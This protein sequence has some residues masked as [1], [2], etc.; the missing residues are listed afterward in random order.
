MIF[1]QINVLL[2]VAT[3]AIIGI[4]KLPDCRPPRWRKRTQKL[5]LAAMLLCFSASVHA[6]DAPSLFS[7]G[8]V[9]LSPFATASIVDSE[10]SY[11]GGL[12]LGYSLTEKLTVE[13]EVTS[14]GIDDSQWL[15]S[16]RDAGGN[17]KYYFPLKQTGFAPYL[18]GGYHRDFVQHENL[19]AAGAGLEFRRDRFSIFA[20]AQAIHGFEQELSELGNAVRVRA[21]FGFKF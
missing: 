9:T 10:L 5:S 13:A 12:A 16:F 19:L 3:L 21:G 18:I 17:L 11:G 2:V 20:D 1:L 8:R 7:K 15:E 6:A 14:E 4:D